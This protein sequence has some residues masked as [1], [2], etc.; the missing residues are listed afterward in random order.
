MEDK[1]KTLTLRL[2][3]K[4]WKAFKIKCLEQDISMH[5][6]LHRAVKREVSQDENTDK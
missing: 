1:I 6:F 2:S 4:D 5:E 3:E